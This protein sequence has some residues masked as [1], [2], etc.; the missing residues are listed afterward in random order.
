MSHFIF[1]NGKGNGG[2]SATLVIDDLNS[3]SP[4]AALSANQG[5]I[6][7]DLIDNHEQ[8]TVFDE[9]GVHGIRFKDGK[10]Q[11]LEDE[12]W[13]D[14]IQDDL[15]GFTLLHRNNY[16]ASG[17][18]DT[19]TITLD[20]YSNEMPTLVSRNGI[21]LPPTD[22]TIT[23]NQVKLNLVNDGSLVQLLVWY[24]TDEEIVSSLTEYRDVYIA[25]ANQTTFAISAPN[26]NPSV[27]T[28]V[29]RNGIVLLPT[30]YTISG[31]QV[32]I[33]NVNQ[34]N[35]IQLIV[36]AKNDENDLSPL[37]LH[38]DYYTTGIDGNTDFNITARN[39]NPLFPTVVTRGGIIIP[40]TDYSIITSGGN[41]SVRFN[42]PIQGNPVIQILVWEGLTGNNALVLSVNGRIGHVTLTNE[43]VNAPSKEEF[44]KVKA[45]ASRIYS[46]DTAPLDTTL[47]WEDTS[48]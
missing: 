36:F 4:T 37:D 28:I 22:Y 17:G 34:G 35:L 30:D 3:T 12:V 38:S 14:V 29:S 21:I 9:E 39:Y 13:T 16:I 2:G 20:N 44:E 19:F 48:L 42:T 8:K 10:L 1:R 32:T 25:S 27:P 40:N 18:N 26:Y 33:N 45:Q 6:L 46:G 31:N 41:Y 23:G 5:K 11:V 15:K 43:D 47:I 7:K 24:N